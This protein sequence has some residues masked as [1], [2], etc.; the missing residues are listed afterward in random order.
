[1]DFLQNPHFHQNPH[2]DQTEHLVKILIL[3]GL[4]GGADLG[5]RAPKAPLRA[6]SARKRAFSQHT[7]TKKFV[8]F[9]L[10][11]NLVNLVN[12]NKYP[13]LLVFKCFGHGET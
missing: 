4:G 9:L 7:N 10:H 6:R 3:E 8:P 1:M 2:F 12:Y 13:G 5:L 11:S